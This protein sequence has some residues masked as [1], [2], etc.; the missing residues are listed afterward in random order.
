[1]HKI[2]K[3]KN[4]IKSYRVICLLEYMGKIL[5]K[6]VANELLRICEERSLLYPGQMGVRKNRSAVDAV[7]LLIYEV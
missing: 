7:V 1:M 4:L 3:P 2:G 6:V 5:E